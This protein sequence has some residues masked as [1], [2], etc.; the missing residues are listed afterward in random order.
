MSKVI[1]D[2]FPWV[3]DFCWS[4]SSQNGVS[5]VQ[6]MFLYEARARTRL[7]QEHHRHDR[8][9]IL[10]RFQLNFSQGLQNLKNI[11]GNK[12]NTFPRT[13]P[14]KEYQQGWG[15]LGF[16]LIAGWARGSGQA[17]TCCQALN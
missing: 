11:P 16:H 13:S 17:G 5:I 10:G 15:G 3:F 6:L 8:D 7:G 2:G 9:P 4:Q 14:N 1:F 12:N